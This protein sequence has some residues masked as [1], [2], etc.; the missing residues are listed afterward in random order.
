MQL[1]T[2]A[3]YIEINAYP[4]RVSSIG[5]G[6]IIPIADITEILP[7]R[8]P[9]ELVIRGNEVIFL[10]AQ[11]K[12]ELLAWS[13]TFSIPISQRLDLW[14][15]INEPFLDTIHTPD[16]VEQ[17]KQMLISNQIK[18]KEIAGIREKVGETL[19][20]YNALLWEWQHLG[21]Y[22]VLLSRKKYSLQGLR[23]SFY[24]WTMKI[25]LRN[26]N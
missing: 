21:Q 7:D 24:W 13:S 9:P 12:E 5:Q 11:Y 22:E 2:G 15:L 25:A 4:F 23:E 16:Q 6:G 18:E 1:V 20:I 17:V 8:S 10:D 3:D 26:L 19:L 14:A